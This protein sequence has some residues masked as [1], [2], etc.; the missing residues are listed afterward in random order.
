LIEFSKFVELIKRPYYETFTRLFLLVS[1][2]SHAQQ[3]KK[4]RNIHLE[5]PLHEIEEDYGLKIKGTIVPIQLRKKQFDQRKKRN[6]NEIATELKTESSQSFDKTLRKVKLSKVTSR[7]TTTTYNFQYDSQGRLKKY[8]SEGGRYGDT[9]ENYSYHS[10]GNFTRNKSFKKG[11]QGIKSTFTK[12]IDG[13]TMNGE[14]DKKLIAENNLVKKIIYGYNKA[15][16]SETSLSYDENGNIIKRETSFATV[17]YQYNSNGDQTFFQEISKRNQSTTSRKYA[18]KYDAYGNWVIQVSLLNMSAA[19]G[20]PSFPQPTLREIKYSNGEVTGTT[21]IS[22]VENDLVMLR[23]EVSNM[24]ISSDNAIATWKRSSKN[25]FR[26]YL[27]NKS[28]DKAT[29]AYMGKDVLAF[30][31]D[32]KQLYLMKNAENAPL[33]KVNN[34]KRINVATTHGYWFKKP[35]GG[36]VVFNNQGKIIGKNTLYKYATNNIDVL[37]KGEGEPTKVVLK[38]YKNAQPYTIFPAIAFSQYSPNNTTTNTNTSAK[39]AGT[40]LKGDCEN[41]YG[42]F[43]HTNG[44][45]SEG[46]FKN[47]APYGPMHVSLEKNNESSIAFLQGNYKAYKG[48]QYRFSDNRFT[49]M[50]DYSKEM[51]LM[52]DAKERKSYIY[53]FKNGKVVSKTLL[54]ERT[55][56]G[57][58]CIVGNCTNGPGVY[59]YSNGTFYFGYFKNGRRNGFGRLDLKNGKQY[60]GEFDMDNYSGMGTYVIS[61]Y[62]YYVGEFANNTFN[63]QGVMYYSK[64]SYKAGYWKGGHYQGTS[65]ATNTYTKQNSSTNTKTTYTKTSS[66]TGTKTTSFNSLSTYDKGSIEL[67]KKNASCVANFFQQLYEKTKKDASEAV[68]TKKMTDYFHSLYNMNPDMAYQICFKLNSDTFKSIDRKSLPQPVQDYLKNRAQGLMNKYNDHIKKQGY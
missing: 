65:I 2:I 15:E 5:F 19:Q 49:E 37:F 40:C 58:G 53:N 66:T 42:E 25:N 68:I 41:G 26:F 56:T 38:N 46:F 14:S 24:T 22:K 12:T 35:K 7:G 54:Q 51:G 21:D 28:A 11:D 3:V 10:N 63:G 57:T 60:F 9:Y 64:T 43:K 1:I 23:K 48:M 59:K 52:N 45:M 32:N 50:I 34:A 29:L 4:I 8:W 27:D 31:Q 33:N 67:C 6:N 20:I 39:K 62:N 30:N 36:V 61:E 16:P 55:S 13:Y 17:T 47:G 18:Y 44:Y